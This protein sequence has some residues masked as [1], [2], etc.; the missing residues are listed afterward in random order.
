MTVAYHR[1]PVLW[2]V[3]YDA[4]PNKLIAIV[5]PNGAGKS[6]LIKAC[7]GLVPRASGQVEFWSEPYRR[8]RPRIGYVPQRE[9]VDWDFPV[10]ALDVV[11]MGRYRKIGWCRPVTR[12]HKQAAIACLERVGIGAIAQKKAG[13]LSFPE[14]A[15]VEVARALCTS[16]KL[17]LLDEVMAALTPAEMEEIIELVRSLRDEGMTF[18]VVEHHMK[19]VMKLCERLIVLNFGEM[20]ADGT[21][22]EIASNRKVLD[23]Y[24][25]ANFS[26]EGEGH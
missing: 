5:G 2:D 8:A 10:S 21:P 22:E 3:D 14:R 6:T 12:S 7:L 13:D 23:A 15:R 9:S 11:C 19:A 24:L 25:G 26:T 1:K 17:L 4:P 20:I 18:I 16:P